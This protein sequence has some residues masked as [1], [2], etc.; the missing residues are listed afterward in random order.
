MKRPALIAVA[1]AVLAALFH[2]FPLFHVVPLEQARQARATKAF[3]P[4]EFAEKFWN[5][6]LLKSL[7]RAVNA[8]V[9][10]PTIQRDP[11]AARKKFSRS[12]GISESYFYFV[13]G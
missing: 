1:I 5:E 4:E 6:R 12:L 11:A 2:F 10:L 7:D 9:L 8:D 13:S 3:N